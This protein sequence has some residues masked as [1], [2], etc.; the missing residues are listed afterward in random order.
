[1]L[2]P[3]T[4]REIANKS[5]QALEAEFFNKFTEELPAKIK[6]EAAKGKNC[7]ELEGIKGDYTKSN[8]S[9]TRRS[10]VVFGMLLFIFVAMG[11]ILYPVIGGFLVSLSSIVSFMV[12]YIAFVILSDDTTKYSNFTGNL[13]VAVDIL[14]T[15]D[16]KFDV[17]ERGCRWKDKPVICVYW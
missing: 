17:I 14:K 7:L 13:K 3:Q 1:M 4:A 12:L 8:F 15:T 16:F 9:F 10:K 6:V 11:L 5:V 2:T